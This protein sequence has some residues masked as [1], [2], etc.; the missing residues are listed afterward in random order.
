MD[1]PQSNLS[2]ATRWDIQGFIDNKDQFSKAKKELII[3]IQKLP[4]L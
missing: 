3:Y 2:K 4:I 1:F